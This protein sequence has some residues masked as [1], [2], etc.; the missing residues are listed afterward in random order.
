MASSHRRNNMSELVRANKVSIQAT[1]E[2]EL[3]ARFFKTHKYIAEVH[4]SDNVDWVLSLGEG[5]D[6]KSKTARREAFREWAIANADI[7]GINWNPSNMQVIVLSAKYTSDDVLIDAAI[8][9]ITPDIAKWVDDINAKLFKQDQGIHLIG[10]SCDSVNEVLFS[11]KG[12]PVSPKYNSGNW[13]WATIGLTVT[14]ADNVTGNQAYVQMN[15]QLVSSQLKKPTEIGENGYNLTQFKSEI[16]KDIG[17]LYKKEEEEL[18]V[19]VE[20]IPD[21]ANVVDS[22]VEVPNDPKPK[23]KKKSKSNE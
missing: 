13:A 12:S 17:E 20:E 1:Q 4:E 9:L 6:S 5:A 8:A 11:G 16:M 19:V 21:T 10:I 7:W 23:R 15:S 18:P 3:V 22:N 2:G 14:V